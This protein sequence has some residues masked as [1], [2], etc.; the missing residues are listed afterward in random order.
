MWKV[1]ITYVVLR[2]VAGHMDC[3][4]VCHKY[5]TLFLF[6]CLWCLHT[7]RFSPSSEYG[8]SFQTASCIVVRRTKVTQQM[9]PVSVTRIKCNW[10]HSHHTKICASAMLLLPIAGIET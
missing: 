10:C 9:T 1:I 3:G 6:E 4:P 7:K 8:P 5:A 2:C